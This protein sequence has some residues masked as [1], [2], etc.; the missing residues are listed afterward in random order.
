[1][2]EIEIVTNTF[3]GREPFE[4]RSITFRILGTQKTHTIN[5]IQHGDYLFFRKMFDNE[6]ATGWRGYNFLKNKYDEDKQSENTPEEDKQILDGFA[7][8]KRRHNIT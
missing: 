3:T 6:S 5:H 4:D 1:M 7:E 2:K 8:F